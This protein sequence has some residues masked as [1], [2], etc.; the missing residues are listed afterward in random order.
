MLPNGAFFDKS[1]Q[2]E[3]TTSLSFKKV[4]PHKSVVDNTAAMSIAHIGC[5]FFLMVSEIFL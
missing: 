3:C 4:E 2:C 1:L 5:E